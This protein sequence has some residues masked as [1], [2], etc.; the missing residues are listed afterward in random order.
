MCFVLPELGE[1]PV[2]CCEISAPQHRPGA[3]VE[4]SKT[5]MNTVKSVELRLQRRKVLGDLRAVVYELERTSESAGQESVFRDLR[6]AV[7]CCLV[8]LDGR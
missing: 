2:S 7:D 1:A 5:H 8:R 4:A 3:I 6:T